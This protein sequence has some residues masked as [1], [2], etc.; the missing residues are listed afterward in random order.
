MNSAQELLSRLN[1]GDRVVRAVSHP[2][3]SSTRVEL[4]S[5]APIELRT[6][7]VVRLNIADYRTLSCVLSPMAEGPW[8]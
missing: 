2:H 1:A 4:D 5:G 7:D 6:V 8:R 3:A